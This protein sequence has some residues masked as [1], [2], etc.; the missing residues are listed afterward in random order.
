MLPFLNT[1]I[2]SFRS[3]FSRNHAF[4][5][6]VIAMIGLMVRSDNLGITSIIRELNLDPR[7]YT[8]FIH[9]FRSTSWSLEKLTARWIKIVT[10]SVEKPTVNGMNILIGDGIKVSKEGRKMPGVKKLHQES[11]N[12]GK[13]E[14]MFGH[15]FGVVG[16]LAGNSSKLFCIALSASVQDGVNK[17]REFADSQVNVVSHVVQVIIQAAHIAK[18]IG[19]SLIILDR[20]FL[21]VPALMNL[22]SSVDDSGKQLLHMVAKAKMSMV[23]YADPPAYSGR[24]PRPK[25]GESIKI[26]EMFETKKGNFTFAQVFMYGKMQDVEYYCIDLLWGLKLYQKVR[27]VLINYNGI[28]SILVCTSLEL[29]ALQII[30]Q[31]SY[32]FKI[33][34]GFKEL[35]HTIGA[36]AYHFWSKSMPKLN[37]FFKDINTTAI[38]EPSVKHKIVETLKAIE[39][40]IC[41]AIICMGLLQ[42][43][44]LK[45]SKEL[46]TSSFRWLRTKT[47]SIVSE[48]TVA[49]FFQKNIFRIMVQYSHLNIMQIIKSKQNEELSDEYLD[50]S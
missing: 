46:N 41:I 8:T 22:K 28:R 49:Y 26:K 39:G 10:D 5:W 18:Q 24:G 38:T 36:F 19:P 31:Y 15:L 20:Y 44:S 25:K 50:A 30:Q 40:Y 3:C 43:L 27:I 7:L 45:F 21:S 29:S 35:K 13:A 48:A 12:S 2:L 42:I 34:I 47:N 4:H 14:Y 16:I 9:Y 17:I 32:R 23:A 37:R 1:M 11:E 6:F 33:E